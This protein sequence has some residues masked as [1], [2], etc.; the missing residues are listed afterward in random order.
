MQIL[1]PQFWRGCAQGSGSISKYR[2][3]CYIMKC[4]Y[5][6]WLAS[7]LVET[8]VEIC[9]CFQKVSNYIAVKLSKGC[10]VIVPFKVCTSLL[11]QIFHNTI[12]ISPSFTFINVIKSSCLVLFSWR[13]FQKGWKKLVVRN[14]LYLISPQWEHSRI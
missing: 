7:F 1:L 10:S 12:T 13:N 9:D 3:C 14:I 5:I 2:K 6:I 8:L 4:Y 11:G